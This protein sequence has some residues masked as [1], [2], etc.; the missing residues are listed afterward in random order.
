MF[1]L[2]FTSEW[3]LVIDAEGF[4]R[5]T[6]TGA[7]PTAIPTCKRRKVTG[8]EELSKAMIGSYAAQQQLAEAQLKV[9]QLQAEYYSLKIKGLK[10][11]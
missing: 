3:D 7:A 5:S 10:K 1:T 2:I 4:V 8:S 11:D 6:K 9:A